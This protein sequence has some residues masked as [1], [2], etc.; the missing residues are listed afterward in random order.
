MAY[1][2]TSREKLSSVWG[3]CQFEGII[4]GLMHHAV[5]HRRFVD[6]PIFGVTYVKSVVLAVNVFAAC[7]ILRKR[8]KLILKV[9][10][11]Y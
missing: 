8:K 2:I 6:H 5:S 1:K 7:E 11:K 4:Q 9:T 3:T 10:F